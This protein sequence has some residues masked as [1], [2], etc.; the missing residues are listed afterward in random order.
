MM[1]RQKINRIVLLT[2]DGKGKTTA[3]LGMV[4]RAVGHGKRVCVVQF[5]KRRSDTGESR[6]LALLPGVEQ[7]LCGE[8]FVRPE[9]GAAFATHAE[10]AREGLR[11][12]AAK[13][14]DPS[15]GM[16]VLDEVC[17][18]VA[19]GLLDSAAVLGAIRGA[20]PG[21]T[22]VLTGRDACPELI[23]LADTVSRIECVKHGYD[24]GWPAQEGVEL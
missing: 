19:C 3:A 6:A 1:T 11:L 7:H 24:A 18:A 8:G 16:V 17:G 15:Y 2:G 9:A 20:A 22:V 21:T 10:A 14:G 23:G 5:I 4:L 13:L 12:A